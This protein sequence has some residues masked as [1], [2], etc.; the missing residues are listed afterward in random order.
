MGDPL[1]ALWDF[2]DLDA[3]E[4]RF[5]SLQAEV[6]TQLARVHG[7]RGAF[8]AGEELLAEAER[9]AGESAA[10]RARIAMERGRL[11]RS[12]GDPVASLPLFESA[13]AIADETGEEFLAV[14][15]AHMAAIATDDREIVLAWT[16]RGIDLAEASS[17]PDVRYWLGPLLNNLGWAH[18]EAGEHE[19]A[20]D[21]F[22]RALVARERDSD[23]EYEREIARYAVAKTLRTLGRAQEAAELLE[24]AIAW[25]NSAG[26]PDGSFHEELAESYAALGRNDEAREHARL[27]L[28]LLELDGERLERLRTLGGER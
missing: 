18:Y 15:A 16:R 20:L 5:C 2:D 25:T 1:R 7:L 10:A 22:C 12:G 21:A 11:K 28:T 24:Q 4:R 13:F 3:T 14:D 8:D 23:K 19:A 27:A 6:L 26:E 17:D 9:L